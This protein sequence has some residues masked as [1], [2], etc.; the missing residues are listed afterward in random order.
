MDDSR[1]E[2]LIKIEFARDNMKAYLKL[3]PPEEGEEWPTFDEVMAK[4]KEA[5]VE[6][7]LK[8]NVVERVVQERATGAV[9]IAEG[10]PPQNGEDAELKFLFEVD[11]LKLI[12]KELEDGRVDHRELSLIQNVKK[13]QALVE[14]KPP[15]PGI[16]GRNV[17]GEELKAIPGKDLQITL[18]KNVTWDEKKIYIRATTDGEPTLVGKKV[19]VQTVHQVYGNVGY[20]TGNIDFSGSVHIRGEIESGFTVKAAGDVI[21][22]GNVEGGHVYADGNITV[23]GGIIGQDKSTIKCRGDLI[24]R[25]IDHAQVDVE[26]EV[27]VRDTILHSVV[28][29]GTRVVLG[30]KK[31]IIMGGIVRAEAEVDAQILGSKMG[32]VT[33]VEVGANPAFRLEL[34][35]IEKRLAEL[36][37]EI[38]KVDKALA[39]LN[40][41]GYNLPPEREEMKA[42]LTRTS[43]VLKGEKRKLENRR[44]EINK[45]I[46]EK[47]ENKGRIKVRDTIY[48]GVKVTIGKAVRIFRDEV[49]FAVLAYN[50]G[51]VEVQAYR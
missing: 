29:A 51:E 4:I 50:E 21:I 16:P 42:K 13:G 23:N 33:E 40:K 12:P 26:G 1:L 7:G 24:A 22:T 45:E 10:K 36:A 37:K 31:G 47:E 9:L 28:N 46:M 19:S 39:I 2:R 5:G 8:E 30:S 38:D 20:G 35:E 6:F 27:K 25:Y 11:R 17:K 14:R 18:G 48:P 34:G 41:H 44:E 43:F 15:T 49:H 32:T 3:S